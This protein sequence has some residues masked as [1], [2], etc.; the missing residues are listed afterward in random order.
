ALP[1]IWALGL[2]NPWR[3]SFDPENG[4]LYIGD[5]GRDAWEEIN[6]QPGDSPGG[7]NYEWPVR[8]GDHDHR[9]VPY[10]QGDRVGPIFEYRNVRANGVIGGVVYRGCRM[11][12]LHGRY[13]LAD[14]SAGVRSFLVNESGQAVDV[15]DHTAALNSG[16][17]GEMTNIHALGVDGRGEIYVAFKLH[18]GTFFPTSKRLLRVIPRNK[19]PTA[20]IE[21]TPSP[22]VVTL[23]GGAAEVLL[24]GSSSDDGGD[25][26]EELTYSWRRTRGPTGDTI[27]SEN[28]DSTTVG[29]MQA[30]EYRY[31]LRVND[32]KNSDSESVV[33]TVQEPQPLA[34]F[35]RGDCNGD[36][37]VNIS[38]AVM[39]LR[40]CFSGASVPCAAACDVDG[41]GNPCS[42]VTDGVR[43][44]T[45]LF[46]RGEA[47]PAPFPECGTSNRLEDA[48]LGCETSRCE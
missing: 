25:G 37:T 48:L 7:E 38:D 17:P 3:F 23:V 19:R 46:R 33:V 41:D 4:D 9:D 14:I 26:P 21:T 22:P 20:R 2:R 31:R 18:D 12:D 11:P 8:E 10:G 27:A 47:P 35:I 42:G 16:I 39:D 15:R 24:D 6:Y 30:G 36:G 40:L 28:A 32:G 44:L 43:L 5:V 29:F 1:E 34:H 45:Y 13:F